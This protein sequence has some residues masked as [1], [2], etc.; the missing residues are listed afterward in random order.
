MLCKRGLSCHAVCVHVCL[1]VCHVCIFCRNVY[2]FHTILVFLY[3]TLWQYSDEDPQTGASNAGG[4]D[5]NRDSQR[6]SG[7]RIDDCYSA[8]PFATASDRAI[9]RS[10]RH[11]SV[12]LFITTSMDDHDEEKRREQIWIVRRGKSKAER[13]LD[14]LCFLK[15]LTDTKHRAA[16]RRQQ[17]Y[18]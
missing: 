5:K 14:V 13:A 17:G 2:F 6:I 18:L 4:V 16:W 9:C 15:L 1:S 8:K 7:Y 11:A 3:E 10:D 12:I